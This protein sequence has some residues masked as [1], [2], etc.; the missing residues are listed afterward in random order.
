M[1]TLIEDT[2]AAISTPLG[3]SG[4]GVIRLSGKDSRRIAL[5]LFS[6]PHKTF[7]DRVPVLRKLVESSTGDVIDQAVVTYFQAPR[8]F[9]REDL[10]EISC[11]GTPVVLKAVLGLVLEAG[12]R[13]ASP[14]EFTLRAYLRGRIDLVQ[15]EALRDLIEAQTLFQVKVAHEQATGSISRRIRPVKEDLVQLIA[16]LEA[17]I[18]FAED[19]VSV[20]AEVEIGRRLSDI[21]AGLVPLRASFALGKIVNS[22][23]S[24]A[25]AGRPN[26]G[27]SSVFNA[28]LQ[29]ERAIVTEIPGT[30]RDLVSETTQIQGIPVRL[31]DT[32]GIRKSTDLVEQLGIDRSVEALADADQVLFI[33]DGSEPWTVLDTEILVRL[34]ERPYLLV[35][36]K[37]DL[38]QNLGKGS[39]PIGA[40]TVCRVSAKTGQGI[41]DLRRALFKDYGLLEGHTGL[42]TNVRHEELI[43]ETLVALSKSQKAL[44]TEMPHEVILLD[45]Y[46]ALKALNALTGETTVED[47]LGNIFSRFCIGK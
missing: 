35:V 26:V 13:L 31:M 33:V 29:E 2:I 38:E 4:L 9:T 21:E 6:S 46:A 5:S 39:V 36:N 16:L 47:I 11:H 42:V 20:L 44:M 28:L 30:T 27:K 24:I 22:G 15:A 14:G 25:L 40:K 32:A 10:V 18:D 43:K 3:K 19:D 37:A 12:A 7:Q 45:L 1:P 17:G 8:S 34:G 23:L 41:E